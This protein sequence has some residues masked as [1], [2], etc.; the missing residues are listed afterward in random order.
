MPP[1][2]TNERDFG[3]EALLR[4]WIAAL[5]APA[6][7]PTPARLINLAAR[8]LAGSGD[9]SLIAGFVIAPGASKSVV[10]RAIGPTLGTE[11]GLTSAMADPSLSVYGP[12][13]SSR[14]VAANDNW[15]AGRPSP[16]LAEVRSAIDRVGAF[17]LPLG[18]ADAAVVVTLEPGAYTAQVSAATGAA[19]LALVEVYDADQPASGGNGRLINLSVRAQ[20]GLDANVLI[21]GLVV[22]AGASK[23]LLL[24]AVGPT[25]GEAPFNVAGVLAQ[26]VLTL[27]SGSLA[28]A[29]NAA[30]NSAGNPAEI[31]TAARAV[32]AFPLPDGSRDSAMLVTL[33]AGAY[34][35]QVAGANSTTG[36]ALVEVYEVP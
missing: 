34:T 13:S 17:R 1:L 16:G 28:V 32:G 2:A 25:L 8:S 11:F 22:G 35:L 23:T 30:W 4:A 29:T 27:F 15:S 19:G 14:L 12:N 3:G 7:A 36:V 31:R 33:P 18:S 20:V 24:R 9:A 26:P 10:V 5:A 21:P 6:P